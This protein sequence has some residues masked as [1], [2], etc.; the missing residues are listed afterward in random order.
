MDRYTKQDAVGS[1]GSPRTTMKLISFNVNGIRASVGKGLH[2]TLQ[3]LNADIVCFQ[4]TK[5]TPEQVAAAL[6]GVDGYQVNA[7]GALKLGYSGTAILSRQAP[8]KVV[9]DDK[10]A[11]LFREGGET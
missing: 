1:Q 6:S 9:S 5:A 8:A 11:V 10:V 7:Y 3:Q 2:D 4:E